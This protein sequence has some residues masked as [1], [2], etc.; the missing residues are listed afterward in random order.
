MKKILVFLAFII[1]GNICFAQTLFSLFCASK[2]HCN[3]VDFKPYGKYNIEFKHDNLG[4]SILCPELFTLNMSND[5]VY[6][7]TEAETFYMYSLFD[8]K[9]LN[10]DGFYTKGICYTKH[11]NCSFQNPH[12]ESLDIF[13]DGNIYTMNN[14][15]ILFFSSDNKTKQADQN[16]SF[17]SIKE[18]KLVSFIKSFN[19]S[20]PVNI[21]KTSIYGE[22]KFN[23]YTWEWNDFYS[24]SHDRQNGQLTIELKSSHYIGV[25]HNNDITNI[26]SSRKKRTRW[27]TRKGAIKADLVNGLKIDTA[28]EIIM[29]EVNGSS[30]DPNYRVVVS[31]I[32]KPT[33]NT[34]YCIR[35]SRRRLYGKTINNIYYFRSS[36]SSIW[37]KIK[38]ALLYEL[39]NCGTRID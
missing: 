39:P 16:L 3:D 1:M 20:T 36:D 31:F 9:S 33:E 19:N 28:D 23:G 34:F 17:T 27:A 22:Y 8:R 32:W 15:M 5:L 38:E 12:K 21:P 26:S 11:K 29:Y 25:E 24:K 10:A 37:P 7:E 4:Y 6:K 30:N 13:T 14:A 35:N 18:D 2:V